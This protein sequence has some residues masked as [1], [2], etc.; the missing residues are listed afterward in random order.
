MADDDARRLA[1]ALRADA[2]RE[3]RDE[4]RRLA[5]L[6][7]ESEP[8]KAPAPPRDDAARRADDAAREAQLARLREAQQQ[9]NRLEAEQREAARRVET[10]R[11]A[12]K[13]AALR[14][15]KLID[16]FRVR[17]Q[18]AIRARVR[19][20]PG[21]EGR[22]EA[23]FEVRLVRTGAVSSLRLVR[24]SGSPAY[25]RAVEKAIEEAQPLPVPDDADLFQQVQDLTLVF[26][27]DA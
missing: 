4:R 20:P 2:A 16:D 22:I 15:K 27:P 18:L 11:H 23:V 14:A 19:L 8:R 1:R 5:E 6:L 25:D 13:Q 7:R 24:P 9:V 10:E 12:E 17:I 21:I 3:G 26:R